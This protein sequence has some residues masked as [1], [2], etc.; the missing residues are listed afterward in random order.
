MDSGLDFTASSIYGAM[1]Q[2]GS[3]QIAAPT[4]HMGTN[5]LKGGLRALVD[6]ANPVMWFGVI[7]LAT[8]GLIGVAGSVR[9]G[10]AK[11]SASLDNSG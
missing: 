10:K 1:P 4:E 2:I 5:D 7:L 6:P 9:L 8:F 3:S 11:V